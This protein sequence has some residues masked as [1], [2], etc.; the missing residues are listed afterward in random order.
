MTDREQAMFWYLPTGDIIERDGDEWFMIG[1]SY[2]MEPHPLSEDIGPRIDR[3][4]T[5]RLKARVAELEAALRDGYFAICHIGG[6]GVRSDKDAIPALK[7]MFECICN[8][9]KAMSP[10]GRPLMHRDWPKVGS[11]AALKGSE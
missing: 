6:Y 1:T 5:E 11:G 8:A 7:H 9:Q 2:I 3:D 4:E 10:L